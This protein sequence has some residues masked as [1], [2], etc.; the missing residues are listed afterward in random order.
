MGTLRRRTRL[1]FE[2]RDQVKLAW[3]RG[4]PPPPEALQPDRRDDLLGCI[5]FRWAE[6]DTY[7]IDQ[8]H[9]QE[10]LEVLRMGQPTS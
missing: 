8:P 1:K 5:F 9:L 10:W 7:R 2:D 6:V 3:D 4:L